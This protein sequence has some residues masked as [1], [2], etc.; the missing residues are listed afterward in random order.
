MTDKFKNI[1]SKGAVAGGSLAFALTCAPGLAFA[2]SEGG[3][4]ILLPQPMEFIPMLIAFIVLLIILGKFG[5]PA[6]AKMIDKRRDTI[7]NG[8][9]EAEDAKAEAERLLAEAKTNLEESQKQAA[10]IIA[11]A[12][13]TAEAAKADIAKQASEEAER[14]KATA[15]AAMATEKQAAIAELQAGAAQLAVLVAGRLIGNDLNDA[16]H[17]QIVQKYV[18]EAGSIS[19]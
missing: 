9:K 3:L 5:W 10:D 17:L 18:S 1:A 2:D 8:L 15:Q 4:G 14:I 7:Q 11:Q 13:K 19:A 6:F 12:K 16:Q